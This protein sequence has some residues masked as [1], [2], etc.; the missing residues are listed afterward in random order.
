M[1]N[2]KV[3]DREIK[4]YKKNPEEYLSKADIG[5]WYKYSVYD[6]K[7]K[8]LYWELSTAKQLGEE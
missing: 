4:E 7:W 2:K 5:N 8:I 1:G 6:G 3:L